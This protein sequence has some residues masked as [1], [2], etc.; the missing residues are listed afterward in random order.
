F[1]S[2]QG[3]SEIAA[4]VTADRTHRLLKSS[5]KDKGT[6][7]LKFVYLACGAGVASFLGAS[8][9]MCT[10]E[11]QAARIR[12]LYLKTILRQDVGFFDTE[13]STG[14][15]IGRMSGDIVL[16]QE[17][18]GEKVVEFI[19]CMT[20][21]LAGINV[22]FIKGWKL[23][24]VILSIIPL[25][26]VTGSSMAMIISKMSSRG[27]QAY[28]EAANIV[29]QS[30]GS[31]RTVVSFTGEKKSIEDYDKSLN[32]AYKAFAQQ[33]L[34][35]GFGLGF[36]QFILFC[37]YAF[38]FWYGSR[39][40]LD[41]EYNGG[42]VINVIFAVLMGGMS[43]GQTS[44]SLK[45][46]GAGLAAAY[47]IVET[48]DRK[49]EIDVYDTT[50]LVL[51]DIQG[52]IEL[53]DV[54][55]R[56]PA[57]PDVEIFSGFSLEIPRGTT[58][59]LVGE[60]GSGKSTVISL[61]ERFYDPQAGV[62]LIDGV[63]IKKF[64]LKWIRQKIGLVSQEPVL[65]AT[66]IKENLLYG[67]DGATLEELKAAA[68]LANA[69]KFINKLPQGFDTMVGEHGTQLSGGQKQRIA[70]ARAILK[71]PRILLLDEATSALDAKSER[72]VQEALDRI[73]VNRTTVIVAHHLTTIRNADVIAVVQCG[74]IVEKGSHS[75]LIKNPSGAYSHLIR[76]QE[77]HQSKEQDAMINH[78]NS[79]AIGRVSLQRS[80]HRLSTS[81]WSPAGSCQSPSISIAYAFPS[82]VAIQETRNI[83]ESSQ[84]K[85]NKKW[86]D[87]IC[88]FK[89]NAQRDVEVG[90][91]DPEKDVP[92]LHLASLNKPEVPMLILG[93][94]S[95]A[96]N[97]VT[98]PV[99]GFFLSSVVKIFY[100]PDHELRKYA[101]FWALMFAILGLGCLLIEPIQMYCFAIAG[102]KLVQRIRSLTF[103]K[104]IYQEIGW[105]DDSENS[106]G[107][108]SARLST[109]AATVCSMVGDALSLVVQ[110]ISTIIAA[111]VISFTANWQLTLLIL[112]IVP[113]LGLQGYVQTKFMNGFT[114]DAK[115]PPSLFSPTM[116][117][118]SSQIDSK[119]N[120]GTTLGQELLAYEEATQIANDAVGSIRTVASFSA[121]DKVINLYNEKCSTP[122][123]SGVKHGIITGLGLGFSSFVMFS[124]YSLSF[125][126]GALLVKDGKTTFDNVFKVFSALS[127]A[128][129]GVTLS[130]SLAPDFAKVKSSVNSVF[131]IVDRISKIDANDVS[132]TTLDNVKGDIEFYHVTF[133]YPARQN[134]PIFQGLCLFIHSG[135]T[136]G[137]V[138]ESGSGKSTVIALLERFYDPDSGHI[139]LDGI[140]IRK[141]Q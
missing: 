65:F 27:Q 119:G 59:A 72:V 89:T 32:I 14:E 55:F 110:N 100:E 17:A 37:D 106:S 124:Q 53:K 68:E 85:E 94:I 73:M 88:Y 69:A 128:A 111:I 105:F 13:T 141:L 75:Q 71:D 45:A 18:M 120:M 82:G 52:D 35:S 33:G 126:A 47:K 90:Q 129:M 67:K 108:I 125:W 7:A 51:E 138:G 80:P 42:D 19:Q 44:P 2:Q 104:V 29:E 1:K 21:F 8:C 15:I 133:K 134:M 87:L 139:L 99:F 135:K 43:L 38:A 140:D 50:G 116:S 103:A 26:V 57:R 58:A 83:E 60:S 39:L 40:I 36:V 4:S 34:A 10:A 66:T 31:I 101:R 130:T 122:L 16:I 46:I 114:A 127:M 12:S 107:A 81:S 76:L 70:I 93:S 56:Y 63:N 113:F 115:P 131:K 97:G 41:E 137:L 78:D 48:I 132:G 6:I 118:K 25:L 61:I 20:I 23:T 109:D 77:V 92:V 64:Q 74:S 5:V 84:S 95:A 96:I 98:F 30:I 24:L 102:G 54:Q 136:V 117:T 86:K 91:S 62:V 22:A 3:N 28:A 112:A 11:R 79:N 121:E 9:W 123:K 49:P